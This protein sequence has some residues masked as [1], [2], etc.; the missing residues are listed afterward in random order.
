MNPADSL[1]LRDFHLPDAVSWWPPAL[2]WWLMLLLIIMVLAGLYVLI[3]HL[4][5]PL[6]NKSAK[7]EIYAAIDEF[8]QHSDGKRLVQDISIAIRRI[9]ISYLKRDS[10]AGIAGKNWYQQVNNLVQRNRLTQEV[11]TL[12]SEVPYQK[13]PELEPHLL[14]S[15]ISQSSKW[16]ESLPKNAARNITGDTTGNIVDV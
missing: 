11:V 15:L 3:K 4:R 7:A 2:G 9:G 14:E 1:P 8:S 16:V 13:N 10:T 12:L 6:L 5:K